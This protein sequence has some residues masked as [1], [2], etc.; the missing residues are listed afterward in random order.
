[1]NEA[2]FCRIPISDRTKHPAFPFFQ[3]AIKECE[4]GEE[5]TMNAWWWFKAGWMAREPMVNNQARE[6]ARNML[7]MTQYPSHIAR[8]QQDEDDELVAN[9]IFNNTH[10]TAQ[11]QSMGYGAELIVDGIQKNIEELR[12]YR[13]VLPHTVDEEWANRYANATGKRWGMQTLISEI[14]AMLRAGMGMVD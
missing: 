9:H 8:A 13:Y 3:T 4:Y 7:R 1:M 14:H 10:T 6:Q 2:N 5:A 11:R 12:K